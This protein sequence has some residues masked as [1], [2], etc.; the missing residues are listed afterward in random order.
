VIDSA[1]AQCGVWQAAGHSLKISINIS[2]R[3]LLDKELVPYVLSKLR[4]YQVAPGRICMELTESA[5]MEDPAR[6]R[7]TLAQLHEL[8]LKLS[9][10]DYGTG[11]SSLAYIKDL[12]LDELKI[13]RAFV[14]GM[15]DD[16][17]S[18]AIVHSTIELGHRLGMIVVAE[19]VETGHELSTLKT[20]GCDYA[21][22]YHVCRPMPAAEVMAWMNA[23][24]AAGS[25]DA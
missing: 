5:L 18:A 16:A 17:Q 1:I 21:Q 22:G 10:D 13:D 25:V 7:E 2:A 24:R 4:E 12:S 14:S 23:K 15:N 8:G 3:D 9:M 6:A 20:F 19:G 11:Y